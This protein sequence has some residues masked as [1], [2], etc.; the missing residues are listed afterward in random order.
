MH[1]CQKPSIFGT[2]Y[3]ASL[4]LRS[5]LQFP[6]NHRS[7]AVIMMLVVESECTDDQAGWCAG[8]AWLV[9]LQDNFYHLH[10]TVF[11]FGILNKAFII[12][13]ACLEQR[14]FSTIKIVIS[15]WHCLWIFL[16]VYSN[17]CP[18]GLQVTVVIHGMLRSGE[19]PGVTKFQMFG[20]D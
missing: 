16:C 9:R 4:I 19:L 14:N 1:C 5:F 2:Y 17:S 18:V 12:H 20:I 8:N 11:T 7:V 3:E 10:A 15:P 13:D 6:A